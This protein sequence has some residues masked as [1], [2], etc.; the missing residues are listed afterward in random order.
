MEL[1][2]RDLPRD[3]IFVDRLVHDTYASLGMIALDRSP[4]AFLKDEDR[5]MY[6]LARHLPPALSLRASGEEA[7][8]A[9]FELI[10]RRGW[11]ACWE[12]CE[13]LRTG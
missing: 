7:K 1:T 2:T 13:R 4:V 11:A 6:D 8:W 9:D 10:S 3:T 5:P 12:F